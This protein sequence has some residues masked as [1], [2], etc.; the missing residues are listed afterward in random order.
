MLKHLFKQK[1]THGTEQD[2]IPQ[3]KLKMSSTGKGI[4]IQIRLSLY[5]NGVLAKLNALELSFTTDT[6]WW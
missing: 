2:L 5:L 3:C 1:N 4:P 6:E